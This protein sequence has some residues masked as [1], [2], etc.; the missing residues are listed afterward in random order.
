MGTVS[1]RIS[2]QTMPVPPFSPTDRLSSLNAIT[3]GDYVMEWHSSSQ[4]YNN[5]MCQHEEKV[6]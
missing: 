6:G 3:V 1:L 5:D 2:T 4:V